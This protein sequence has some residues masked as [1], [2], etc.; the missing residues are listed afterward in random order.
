MSKKPAVS[1]ET[2]S[3]KARYMVIDTETT[4]LDVAS[5]HELCEI[6]ALPLE[7][8]QYGVPFEELIN[9]GRS[10]PPDASAINGITDADVENAPTAG[11]IMPRLLS[12][13]GPDSVVVLHNAPFDM[14]FIQ[15]KLYELDLPLISNLVIDTL[16]LAVRRFGRGGNSLGQL[17]TR[18]SLQ[19][20]QAHR[21]LGDTQTTASLFLYFREICG[22]DGLTTV[23]SLGARAGD[24]Y[25]PSSV[26]KRKAGQRGISM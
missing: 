6:A 10:I 15:S 23:G 1:L 8:N 2:D 24:W 22:K 14:S 25:Q 12:H 20:G 26:I 11:E 9:P 7:G 5:G 3:L 17:A 13:I 18:L 4:G 21:A 16:D 19:Q